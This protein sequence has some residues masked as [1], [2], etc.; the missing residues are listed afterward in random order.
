[1]NL[2]CA[3]HK[4]PGLILTTFLTVTIIW[5]SGDCVAQTPVPDAPARLSGDERF[6]L[7][8]HS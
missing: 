7:D 1:M 3:P 2:S 6:A 4:N 8:C 5:L